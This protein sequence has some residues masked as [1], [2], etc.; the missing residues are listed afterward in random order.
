MRAKNADGSSCVGGTGPSKAPARSNEDIG[1]AERRRQ[2]FAAVA[3]STHIITRVYFV[4]VLTPI[5][6]PSLDEHVG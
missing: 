5:L 2:S 6:T 1:E 3:T 4:N